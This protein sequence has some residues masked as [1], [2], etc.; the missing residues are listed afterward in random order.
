MC[1]LVPFFEHRRGAVFPVPSPWTMPVM[2]PSPARTPEEE[3]ERS[4][5][6]EEEEQQDQ[7]AEESKT[8]AEWVMEWTSISVAIV[9]I[10]CR[11]RFAGRRF[12]GDR[13]ALRNARP[14][15]EEG[16]ARDRGNQHECRDNP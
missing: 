12:D 13:R 4:Q 9:R 1:T 3:A 5:R 10:G 11:H 15:G 14:K 7:E 6:G 16:N 8:E 2:T